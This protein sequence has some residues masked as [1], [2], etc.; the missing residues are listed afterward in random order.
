MLAIVTNLGGVA[1]FS[2][3]AIDLKMA[4]QNLNEGGFTRAVRTDEDDAVAALDRE[5]EVFVNALFAVGLADFLQVDDLLIGTRRLG[6][7]ELE[8]LARS[9][10]LFDTV[11][12]FQRLDAGLNL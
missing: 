12:F 3:A 11:E 9:A 6:E 2:L 5:V 8:R 4:S 10:G 1:G 7:A